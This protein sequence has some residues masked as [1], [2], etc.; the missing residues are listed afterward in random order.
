VPDQKLIYNNEVIFNP[1]A[2]PI[3]GTAAWKKARLLERNRIAASKCRQRKKAAQIRLKEDVLNYERDI[4]KLE[5]KNDTLMELYDFVKVKFHSGED[6]E[7][8]KL[9][10][11]V[12][13]IVDPDE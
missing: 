9:L 4:E 8:Q 13:K 2:G 6:D 3:P 12:Q 5:E 1:D 11:R 10:I 7:L